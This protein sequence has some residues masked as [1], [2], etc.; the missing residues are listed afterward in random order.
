[1]PAGPA[2]LEPL[3]VGDTLH[4]ILVVA[5][6]AGRAQHSDED[7]PMLNSFAGQAALAL[8]RVRAQEEREMIVVLEDR[9]RIARDLH[10][11]VIQ[12]LFATGLQ[13]QTAAKLAVRPEIADR[14]RAAVDDLDT[15]IRDIRAAVFELRTP[16]NAALRAAIRDAVDTASAPLGFRPVLELAGP[17]DSAVPDLIRPDLLAVVQEALSNVVRHANATQVRVVVA[18]ADG[19]L[20]VAVHDNGVGCPAGVKSRGG[21][22]NLRRRARDHGGTFEIRAADPTGTVVE[23]SVPL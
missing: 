7:L 6:S 20:T 12:R 2:V 14:V 18:A 10:D 16:S 1:V 22:R 13:L 15:T 4:G 3:V 11:V 9:E 17:I 21:L 8:E 23:W 19:R 5:H